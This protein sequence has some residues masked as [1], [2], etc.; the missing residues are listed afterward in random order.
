M[1]FVEI[2]NSHINPASIDSVELRE[3]DEREWWFIVNV[4]KHVYRS[5]YFTTENAAKMAK[6]E[7]IAKCASVS[8]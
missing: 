6:E 3:N 5:K 2:G 4:G 7:F 1:S 8:R